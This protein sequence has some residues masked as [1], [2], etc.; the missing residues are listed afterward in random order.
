M[1]EV[2]ERGRRDRARMVLALLPL[3]PPKFSLMI[4]SHLA[5]ALERVCRMYKRKATL[6][7]LMTL[8]SGMKIEIRFSRE[9]WVVLI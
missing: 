3:E 9:V 4:A 7:P 8:I 5:H 6:R 2:R 1:K